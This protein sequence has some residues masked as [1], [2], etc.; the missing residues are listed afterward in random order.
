MNDNFPQSAPAAPSRLRGLLI[1]L[2]AGLIGGV[3]GAALI[4]SGLLPIGQHGNGDAAI[5][6]YIMAHPEILPQ[7]MDVL[8]QREAEAQIGQIRQLVET[9]FPGSVLGNPNGHKVLVE[10]MDYAC[11]YCRKSEADV[12]AMA[13][14]D[15][16]LKVVIRQLPILS[17]E[18]RVAAAV[19]L[20]AAKQGKFAAFHHAMY[21]QE[22]PDEAGIEAAAK[23]A[24]VDL[25]RARQDA[26]SEPVKTEIATNLEMTKQLGINSTPTFLANGHLLLGAVGKE[27]LQKGLETPKG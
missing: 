11:G 7:A 12:A 5:H 14:A 4:A 13:A 2:S 15:P 18:S 16:D 25:A 3:A 26:T 24:G 20:G 10:F 8:R 21:A 9:P 22:R 17:P 19:A 1:G 27:A 23:A 6:D